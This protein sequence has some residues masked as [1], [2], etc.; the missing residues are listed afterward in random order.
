MNKPWPIMEVRAAPSYTLKVMDNNT[1]KYRI[2]LGYLKT[3]KGW[4]DA[5]PLKLLSPTFSDIEGLLAWVR[6]MAKTLG[7]RRFAYLTAQEHIR[8]HWQLADVALAD[9]VDKEIKKAN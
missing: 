6:V 4:S 8:G 9:Q 1:K 7:K 5:E 3:A 2:C